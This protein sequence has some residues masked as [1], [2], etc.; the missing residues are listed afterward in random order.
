MFVRQPSPECLFV[1]ERCEDCP[2]WDADSCPALEDPEYRS[3]LLAVLAVQGP[4]LE[5][6]RTRV[7]VILRAMRLH[8]IPL[9][10]ESIAAMVCPG[11]PDL[12]SSPRS[13]LRLL[14]SHPDK[15]EALAAGVYGLT[16]S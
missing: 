8:G 9:H 4:S 3:Y 2:Y 12:F 7:E 16:S 10:W 1:D 6:Q 11:R 15:F 13:V 14:S 5:L